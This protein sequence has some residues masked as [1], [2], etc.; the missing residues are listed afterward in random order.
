MSDKRINE[1]TQKLGLEKNL[2]TGV[3]FHQ[4]FISAFVPI[5]LSL[6]KLNLYFKYKKFCA[7]LSYKKAAR[8]MLIILTQGVQSLRCK[9]LM[10]QLSVYVKLICAMTKSVN[11]KRYA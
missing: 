7:K 11:L 2:T 6:K 4:H 3:Q 10:H 8:K 5:S 9:V 1:L